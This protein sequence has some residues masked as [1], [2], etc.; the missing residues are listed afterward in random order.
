MSQSHQDL[1]WLEEELNRHDYESPRIADK[2]F[3]V[4]LNINCTNDS[5][6]TDSDDSHNASLRMLSEINEVLSNQFSDT[7][8]D[9]NT[10]LTVDKLSPC[11]VH[12]KI[13]ETKPSTNIDDYCNMLQTAPVPFKDSVTEHGDFE[14]TCTD[15]IQMSLTFCQSSNLCDKAIQ[16][17]IVNPTEL[18]FRVD[19][20][21]EKC[22]YFESSNRK[23]IK[24]IS[25]LRDKLMT[26]RE[27]FELSLSL[28]RQE[29]AH[30][31]T[32]IEDLLYKIK[33]LEEQ[34]RKS[35]LVGGIDV[36]VQSELTKLPELNKETDQQVQESS[37]TGMKQRVN[38]DCNERVKVATINIFADSHGRGLS[39]ILC[40]KTKYRIFGL[41]KPG[42]KAQDILNSPLL[43]NENLQ[44]MV[45][46]F[47]FGAN[48]TYCNEAHKFLRALKQFLAQHSYCNIVVCTIPFRYDLPT[49]SIVNTEIRKVNKILLGLRKFFRKLVVIDIS[50]IG[51]RFH[52]RHGLHLNPLGKSLI[53]E[54]ILEKSS[55][56]IS[57]DFYDKKNI[58]TLPYEIQGNDQ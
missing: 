7:N 52:T 50:N 43:H 29:I 39:Q 51:K 3:R 6:N 23:L 41:T 15:P 47:L 40:R 5:N 42:A 26:E 9:T 32:Q 18:A 12:E 16:V 28:Q 13:N 57:D 58:I 30:Q 8:V 53:S 22:K 35:T 56:I 24:D 4:S 20:L 11:L 17:S 46:V 25:V 14:Q 49:W 33:I 27:T 31:I 21:S 2:S 55:T 54:M 38:D 36:A 1:E 34:V 10:D 19:Y 48:D 37:K 44:S 45:S